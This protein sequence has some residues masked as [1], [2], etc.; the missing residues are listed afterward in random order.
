MIVLYV[1]LCIIGVIL[2][3]FILNLLYVA[4]LAA[5]A[6]N[7]D[8]DKANRVY[9]RFALYL[10]RLIMFFSHIKIVKSGAEKL[11]EVKGKFLLVGNHRSDFDPFVTLDALKRTDLAFVSKPE[12]FR[13]P[14]LGRIARKCMFTDIDRDNARNAFKTINRTAG[15]IKDGVTN[16]GIYPEGTRSK[17]GNMLPFHDGVF[18]IAQ[19]AGAPIVVV[20]I[21][22]TEKVHKNA[23]WK[24]TVVYFDVLEVI[25]AERVAKLSS[26]ELSDTVYNMILKA[27]EGK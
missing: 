7:K 6:R 25:D 12:N 21:S 23:P 26:H 15:L 3:F 8:Y 18:K 11:D 13:I 19:K 17:S 20:A 24:K 14:F 2:G 9:V 22:G 4:I 1:L 16:F 5:F 10:S 27:T